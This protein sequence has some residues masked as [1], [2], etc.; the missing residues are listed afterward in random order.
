MGSLPC[1]SI[2]LDLELSSCQ[3]F[4]V[5]CM[6]A[7]LRKSALTPC[8][9]ASLGT[10]VYL[11]RHSCIC[12]MPRD[13]AD[14]LTMCICVPCLEPEDGALQQCAGMTLGGSLLLLVPACLTIW[15]PCY[16]VVSD[17]PYPACKLIG[18]QP[19]MGSVLD[20]KSSMGCCRTSWRGSSPSA[21]ALQASPPHMV[22]K[23]MPCT[24]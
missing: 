6:Y 5:V 10:H 21:M 24:H 12:C 19:M 22:S 15:H 9:T 14:S 7:H 3:T 20:A 23:L 11:Q 18:V 1:V 16:W 13:Q 17:K 8:T 2:R 4:W